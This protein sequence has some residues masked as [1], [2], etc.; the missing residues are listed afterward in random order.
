MLT[1]FNRRLRNR[2]GFTL[3]ELIVV[4]GIIGILVAIAVPRLGLF[5]DQAQNAADEATARTIVSSVALIEA[6]TGVDFDP[7][8]DTLYD[9][10]GD[11]TSDTKVLDEL[12]SQ[13]GFQDDEYTIGLASAATGATSKVWGVSARAAD[14]TITVT[15]PGSKGDNTY[16]Y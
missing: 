13:I 14:G 12:N 11:G 3:I 2:K 7:T 4:I 15:Q 16:T 6:T 9:F 8:S 5:T 10:N 1:F